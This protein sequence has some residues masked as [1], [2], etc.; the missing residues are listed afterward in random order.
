MLFGVNEEDDD[1]VGPRPVV[2]VGIGVPKLEGNVGTVLGVLVLFKVEKENDEDGWVCMD[3][4]EV[5]LV[6]EV[7]TGIVNV[8]GN[9]EIVLVV[10][11]VLLGVTEANPDDG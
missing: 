3:D 7:G 1:D 4:G 6:F 11:V 8:G 10:F 2:G 9:I 5:M